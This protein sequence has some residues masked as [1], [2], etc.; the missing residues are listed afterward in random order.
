MAGLTHSVA[1]STAVGEGPAVPALRVSVRRN[2]PG[3]AGSGWG[4]ATTVL[5]SAML[6][7]SCP[8]GVWVALVLGVWGV[9]LPTLFRT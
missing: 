1:R 8:A 2:V 3:V 7:S 6:P 4:A 5:L 9:A